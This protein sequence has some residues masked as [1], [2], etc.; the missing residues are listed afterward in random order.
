MKTKN[1]T[2]K[3]DHFLKIEN[4]KLKKFFTMPKKKKIQ[5]RR[6]AHCGS[7]GHNKATC[8]EIRKQKKHPQRNSGSL[9]LFVHHVETPLPESPHVINLKP[10]K[11]DVWEKVEPAAPKETGELFFSYHKNNPDETQEAPALPP[12]NPPKTN[13]KIET[14]REKKSSNDKSRRIKISNRHLAKINLKIYKP[15]KK[16]LWINS[17]IRN[18][19]L[20]SIELPSIDLPVG[21]T[22]LAAIFALAI[23]ILPKAAFGYYQSLSTTKNLV[24][25]NSTAGFLSL[26]ESSVALRSADLDQAAAANAN[27]VSKFNEALSILRTEHTFLQNIA[28]V[29][30]VVRGEVLGREKILLAGQQIAIGNSY[31][32]SALKDVQINASTTLTSRLDTLFSALDYANPNYSQAVANLEE[33]EPAVLPPEYQARF[34]DFLTLF[35]KLTHDFKTISSLKG[36]IQ[37]IFGG[38][39]ERHYLLVF[40]NPAELRPTGGFMGTFAVLDVKDGAIAKLEIPPGGTYDLQGQLP[41]YSIPP[42]PL[43]LSNNR[44]EF[45]DANWYPD[46]PAS[47]QKILWFYRQARNREMDGVIAINSTVLERILGILGPVSDES[48]NLTLSSDD[49]LA[50]IQQ[51]VEEGP[52]KKINKPKQVIADLAP[53]I[54]ARMQGSG[55]NMLLPLLQNFSEALEQK[56][57][58]AYFTD[59]DA[60][61]AVKALGWSG[62]I[63]S[64]NSSTDYLFVVN[65]NIQGQKSDAEIKQTIS[66]EADVDKDGN[67]IDTVVVTRE[68]NGVAGEK[69]YGQTNIDYLRIYAPEGSTLISA[70]GFSWPDE[71]NFR[72]P[73]S[74]ALPDNDLRLRETEVG[75][76]PSS[77]TS[78]SNQFGKTAFGNWVVTEPGQTSLVKLT[79]RLP[80]KISTVESGSIWDKTT[81]SELAKYSL[82]VQKQSGITSFFEHQVIF[83]DLNTPI[84]GGGE[85]YLLAK[86]GGRTTLPLT[87]DKIF[88]ILVKQPK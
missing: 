8:P 68:H 53:Q 72:A 6:C 20:P 36:D 76:D 4:W 24:V 23:L 71:K 70:E 1:V 86:N 88:S 55:Q 87:E 74:W 34:K 78:I 46:F 83:P 43:T 17:K 65:T 18:W 7:V 69:F 19:A 56:E 57:I 37:Y 31:L 77:G 22:V 58:Q 40:Q 25:E 81:S 29:I 33:V 32:L 28:S 59:P 14:L 54:L 42:L 62:A 48:R 12:A 10:A 16:K 66:H 41:D 73:D 35:E 52:E 45:Q 79:Y 38:K 27:A 61:S 44:W 11:G 64:A 82:L 13:F 85:G 51:I 15:E 50:T 63:A 26:Q 9:S 75:T 80:F 49:A 47:A 39:G 30:P 84:W 5:L 60:Q 21:K 67:I 3:I 2:L